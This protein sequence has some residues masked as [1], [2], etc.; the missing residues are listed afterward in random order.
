ME[1]N[2]SDILDAGQVPDEDP[3]MADETDEN[4]DAANDT[5]AAGPAG[6]S[7]QHLN[8]SQLF[9]AY[10]SVG[11]RKM[12]MDIMCDEQLRGAAEILTHVTNP[13]HKQYKHDLD[14]Q[15]EGLEAMLQWSANRATAGH[16]S[17]VLDIFRAQ[18]SQALF[19]ALRLKHC[20]PPL[21]YDINKI[22]I[23][24]DITLTEKAFK[25]ALHLSANYAWGEMLHQ[26]TLPL[27]CASLLHQDRRKRKRGMNHLKKLVKAI[28]A[29]EDA[30]PTNKALQNCLSDVAFPEEPMA[31][32]IMVL[33]HRG[34]FDLDSE[35]TAE[36]QQAMRKFY[37]GS[38]ST[39]EILE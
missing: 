9:A 23:E 16:Q 38:S 19:D 39:K 12:Y 5:P 22:E 3:D 21:N 7:K 32:E 24:D 6:D 34:D 28:F 27:A 26:Y 37:S 8:K 35:A 33:L 36:V 25:F 4:G 31:R 11:P 30:A 29:A 14:K 20:S 15:T 13:L 17:T 10:K 2:N 1:D 18:S